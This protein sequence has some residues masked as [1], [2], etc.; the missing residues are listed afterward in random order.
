MA[1]MLD[2]A[3]SVMMRKDSSLSASL[4][5]GLVATEKAE[6]MEQKRMTET[7]SSASGEDQSPFDYDGIL[8]HLGQMGKA[9][10]SAFLWLCLPA[11][12]PG[13]AVMSYTFTGAMP[14]YRYIR[15]ISNLK[16]RKCNLFSGALYLVAMATAT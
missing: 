1:Q 13:I 7:S 10:L 12:F 4:L 14:D 11:M 2:T 9:Q 16:K 6:G 15:M 3:S 8:Q 5:N